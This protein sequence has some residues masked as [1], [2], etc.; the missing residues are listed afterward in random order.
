M[1][2]KDEL[3]DVDTKYCTCYYFDDIMEARDI[4]SRNIY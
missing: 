1:E 3:K 2:S 4:N